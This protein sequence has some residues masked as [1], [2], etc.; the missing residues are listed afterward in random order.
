MSLERQPVAAPQPSTPVPAHESG[1]SFEKR[2]ADWQ[3]KGAAHDRASRRKL[4]IAAPI[5]IV[6]AVIV[7]ALL[8]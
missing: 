8:R 1:P 2:W 6:V 5:L 3:A 4:A 7:F